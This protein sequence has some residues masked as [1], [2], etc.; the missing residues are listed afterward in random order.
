MSSTDPIA[1]MLTVIRNGLAANKKAVNIPFSKIKQGIASVLKDEGYVATVDVLDTKP[2]KT[3]KVGLK[4]GPGGEP[5]IHAIDRVSTPGL[6]QYAGRRDLKP[7]IRGFGIS[8]VSTSQG[9]FSDRACRKQ[10]LGGEV[11]C[12]VH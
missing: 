10:R 12:V 3:I 2:A 5:V 9:I 7:I 1:D 6:R 8:I 4:Y 11:L